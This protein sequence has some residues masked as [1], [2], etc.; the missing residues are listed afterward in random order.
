MGFWDWIDPEG[1]ARA[2][3][4]EELENSEAAQEEAPIV[5]PKQA[6]PRNKP[7]AGGG[8]LYSAAVT[9]GGRVHTEQ[10]VKQSSSGSP[11]AD[12]ARDVLT[13]KEYARD[14]SDPDFV[15]APDIARAYGIDKSE[16]GWGM[17]GYGGKI[18]SGLVKGVAPVI[19]GGLMAGR[20]GAYEAWQQNMQERQ[21]AAKMKQKQLASISSDRVM[22]EAYEMA[23]MNYESDY[24]M[25]KT[26][27]PFGDYLAQA[28]EAMGASGSGILGT[29]TEM[30]GPEEGYKRWLA[31]KRRSGGGSGGYET[32]VGIDPITGEE[33]RRKVPLSDTTL[34]GVTTITDKDGRRTVK[35]KGLPRAEDY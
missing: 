10:L 7:K 6:L 31:S 23:R 21:E 15:E 18:L 4:L 9:P 1:A 27:M 3:E 19:G 33:V 29:L 12:I 24:N 14:R 5:K 20:K 34:T 28:L 13:Q 17:K 35:R 16:P 22:R 2:A 11:L 8:T 32:R 25:G 26:D 30:F